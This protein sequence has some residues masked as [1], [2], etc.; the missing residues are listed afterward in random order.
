MDFVP[1]TP[2]MEG[3]PAKAGETELAGFRGAGG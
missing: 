3:G 1:K 2:V